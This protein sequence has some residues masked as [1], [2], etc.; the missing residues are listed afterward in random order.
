MSD[1]GT[2]E[3]DFWE[4]RAPAWERRIDSLN[5]F[6]DAYGLPAIDALAAQPGERIVDIGCGPGTTAIE[7]AQRVGPDGEVIGLDISEGM[8]NAAQRRAA[9]T[10]TTNIRFMVGD[11]ERHT[12]DDGGLDAAFSR[13]GVM[14]FTDAVAAFSNIAGSLRPAGRLACTVWGPLGD[15]PWLFV[16]TLAAGPALDADLMLPGPD[17]PGPFSLAE[18]GRVMALLEGAGF[19]NV[20]VSTVTSART[21]TQAH[22]QDEV[23][24]LLEVGP[25]GEA[26]DAAGERSQQAAVDAVIAAIEPYREA[27]GWRLTGSALVVTAVRPAS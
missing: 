2:D 16:P 17:E 11:L 26:Y 15:N 24:T 25:V 8:V 23:R 13:F 4:R 22:A 27:D 18:P 3:R 20:D 1:T 6:S 10:G 21:V 14:F 19:V 12:V 7:L 9:R 5:L